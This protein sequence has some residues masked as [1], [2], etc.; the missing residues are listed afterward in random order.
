MDIAALLKLLKT[1]APLVVKLLEWFASQSQESQQRIVQ[2]FKDAADD[3][4]A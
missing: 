1:V 3:K 2:E 4:S